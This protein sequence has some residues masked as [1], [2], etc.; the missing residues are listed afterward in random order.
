MKEKRTQKKD[1]VALRS[2]PAAIAERVTQQFGF[3]HC[4]QLR[5]HHL[6][7]AAEGAC[8]CMRQRDSRECPTCAD[9]SSRR[10]GTREEGK[11]EAQYFNSHARV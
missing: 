7:E 8:V 1:G 9:T 6:H 4:G 5:P 2:S 10:K 11:K 3:G